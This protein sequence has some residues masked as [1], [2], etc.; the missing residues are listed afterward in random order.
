[1]KQRSDPAKTSQRE[2]T[3]IPHA[4]CMYQTQEVFF[5]KK[6]AAGPIILFNHL[7]NKSLRNGDNTLES[8]TDL[9]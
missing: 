6:E 9:G 8:P 7:K 4:G 1:M 3:G 2:S 5:P